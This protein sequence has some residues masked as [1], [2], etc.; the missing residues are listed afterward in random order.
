MQSNLCRGRPTLYN[1]RITKRE[2]A[3]SRKHRTTTPNEDDVFAT[4]TSLRL[5]PYSPRSERHESRTPFQLWSA[6]RCFYWPYRETLRT[7]TLRSCHVSRQSSP[8]TVRSPDA[9]ARLAVGRPK[10]KRTNVG[11]VGPEKGRCADLRGH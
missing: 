8:R 7:S 1:K 2:I 9:A 5:Q 6:C 3:K 4:S 11:W 10:S